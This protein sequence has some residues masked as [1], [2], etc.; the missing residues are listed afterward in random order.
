MIY[1][2]PRLLHNVRIVIRTE[3]FKINQ[4]ACRLRQIIVKKQ[5]K[6]TNLRIYCYPDQSQFFDENAGRYTNLIIFIYFKA[7]QRYTTA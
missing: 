2:Q 3:H 5:N 6:T 7:V 1:G 4:E